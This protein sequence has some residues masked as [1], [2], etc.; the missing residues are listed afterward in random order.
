MQ[1]MMSLGPVVSVS[2]VNFP[3]DVSRATEDE[4]M[5]GILTS[6]DS[7]RLTQESQYI[8]VICDKDDGY[9][10]MCR[11]FNFGVMDTRRRRVDSLIQ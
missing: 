10:Y 1:S 11:R 2:Y 5:P 4:R 6:V 7:M 3:L 9:G 8:P